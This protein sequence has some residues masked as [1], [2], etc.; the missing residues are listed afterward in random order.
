VVDDEGGPIS[1]VLQKAP[2]HARVMSVIPLDCVA[3]RFCAP[4]SATLIQDQAAARNI[5]SKKCSSRFDYCQIA[6]PRRV[7]QHN[8]PL[9]Q[10]FISAARP[11]SAN[12]GHST[13]TLFAHIYDDVRCGE[14]KREARFIEQQ[15]SQRQDTKF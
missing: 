3:K 13:T 9:K 7:L 6:T 15:E 1:C 8:P 5:D 2:T 12:S 11:L 4:K 14:Q 10:T